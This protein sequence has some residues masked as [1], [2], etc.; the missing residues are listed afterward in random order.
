MQIFFKSTSAYT[1][2]AYRAALKRFFEGYTQTADAA[3]ATLQLADYEE[4]DFQASL[5]DKTHWIC[6]YAIRKA[7]IRKHFLAN[8]VREH[9]AKNPQSI[10]R[11]AIPESWTLEVDYAEFLDDALDEAFELRGELELNEKR[12]VHERQWFILKPSMADRGAGL[13][14]FSTI[15]ELTTIF[16]ENEPD[17][18][19]ADEGTVPENGA[20]TSDMRF[21]VVQRYISRPLL[22]RNCKFHIRAYVLCIGSLEVYLH[23]NMLLLCSLQAYERPTSDAGMLGKHLT[24][25]CYQGDTATV[26]SFWSLQDKAL[27]K[28]GLWL[29]LKDITR[30]TFK[31]ASAQRI[32]FQTLPNAFEVFGLDFLVDAEGQA[33]LLEVNAF[34]DFAQTGEGLSRLV[35]EVVRDMMQHVAIKMGATQDTAMDE[36]GF[37]QCLSIRLL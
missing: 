24:N 25:T 31:A 30:E 3:C 18:D 9:V 15:D 23:R 13:R 2:E 1:A 36:N 35:D 19:E 10:L 14:L 37:E 20:M 22:L 28:E 21:F 4:L 26:H 33:S 7:L 6:A 34:P 29:Q 8:T 11:R 16:E 27:D 32:H 5:D 12:P 17:A